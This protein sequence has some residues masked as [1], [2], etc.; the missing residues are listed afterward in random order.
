MQGPHHAGSCVLNSDLYNCRLDSPPYALPLPPPHPQML[1]ETQWPGS[2]EQVSP[3]S[4]TS[5]PPMRFLRASGGNLQPETGWLQTLWAADLGWFVGASEH[6]SK[7]LFTDITSFFSALS[8]YFWKNSQ[9]FVC[10]LSEVA[11]PLSRSCLIHE[12]LFSA[13][14]SDIKIR[15]F[16]TTEGHKST[17]KKTKESIG[18]TRVWKKRKHKCPVVGSVQ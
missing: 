6:K 14:S 3:R 1:T 12:D 8:V 10:V 17:G 13:S 18:G 16:I 11:A 15:T 9:E 5:I 4:R 2:P 7:H